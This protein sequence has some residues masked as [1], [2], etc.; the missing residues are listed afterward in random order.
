MYFPGS[1]YLL[2][3]VEQEATVGRLM[4]LCEENYRQ[5]LLIAPNLAEM[6]GS[7][8]SVAEGQQ[9]L[10][11][12]ILE[13]SRYTTLLRLTYYFRNNS[14]PIADPDATLRVYHDARQLE[15]VAIRQS[16]LPVTN[17]YLPPALNDKWKAN[18]FVSKWLNYC[19]LHGHRFV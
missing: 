9:D 6:V 19:H 11:L 18:N 10:H 15:V 13:Q 4:D 7:Y 8:H 16:T 1:E 17:N 2:K 3:L 5:L 12:E 14:K